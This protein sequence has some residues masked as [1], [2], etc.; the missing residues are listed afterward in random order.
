MKNKIAIIGGG[1]FATSISQQLSYNNTNDTCCAFRNI[2]K[3]D[4]SFG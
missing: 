3:K 1:A 2:E 4:C